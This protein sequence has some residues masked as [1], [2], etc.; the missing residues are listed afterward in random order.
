MKSQALTTLLSILAVATCVARADACVPPTGFSDTPPPAVLREQIFVTHT[1]TI[2]VS[3]SLAAVR[4]AAS[5]PLEDQIGK[6]DELPGI[7][8]TYPLTPGDFGATGSRRLDCLTDGSSLVEQVLFSDPKRF[9]Y[10][11]WNYTSEKADAVSYGIGEFLYEERGEKETRI[12]WSYSFA[13]DESHF[14]GK[15]GGLGRF[16]FR[17]FFLESDYA[18]MM[19]GVLASIKAAA[20]SGP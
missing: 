4:A 10:I 8:G 18:K 6:S 1:E 3:R 5:R 9:R 14:P 20:E 19:R 7:A 16:L 15:L 13:L 17:K 2:D 11:V 12:R